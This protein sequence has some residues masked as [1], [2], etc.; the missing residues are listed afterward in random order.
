MK[1]ITYTA[2]SRIVTYILPISII[3]TILVYIINLPLILIPIIIVMG[4]INHFIFF[5]YPTNIFHIK[6]DKKKNIYIEDNLVPVEKIKTICPIAIDLPHSLRTK[7][8]LYRVTFFPAIKIND[9]IYTKIYCPGGFSSWEFKS[10]YNFKNNSFCKN[11]IKC[12][13]SAN[14]F[15][16]IEYLNKKEL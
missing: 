1:S 8:I 9:K 10:D 12:G 11:L 4:T 16:N 7:S 5:N 6:V 3:V 15:Y 2:F 14:R 13:V